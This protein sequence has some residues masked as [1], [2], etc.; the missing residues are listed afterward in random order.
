MV[1]LFFEVLQKKVK[2]KVKIQDIFI[3]LEKK[4]KVKI[5]KDTNSLSSLQF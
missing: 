2:R 4:I 5:Y 3:F 1:K